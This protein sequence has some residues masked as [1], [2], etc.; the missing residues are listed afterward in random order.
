MAGNLWLRWHPIWISFRGWTGKVT[1]LTLYRKHGLE[2]RKFKTLNGD[3]MIY[4]FV[5]AAEQRYLVYTLPCT[6]VSTKLI[7]Q[8]YLTNIKVKYVTYFSGSFNSSIMKFKALL[9]KCFKRQKIWK[10]GKIGK[11][12]PG[13]LN[14]PN[15]GIVQ[16][17]G[18]P[19]V[20]QFSQHKYLN[21]LLH[22]DLQQWGRIDSGI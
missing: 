8:L 11:N 7:L 14:P 4:M 6:K 13:A 21:M 12:Q 5:G 20:F 10:I 17:F 18:I 9:E 15:K 3:I 22:V 19:R 1:I 2:L 16:F